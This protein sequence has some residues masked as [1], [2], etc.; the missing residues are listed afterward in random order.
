MAGEFLARSASCRLEPRV[1]RGLTLGVS[2]LSRFWW[3]M[4]LSQGCCLLA[5]LPV[6]LAGACTERV[7]R[8]GPQLSASER[9]GIY[10]L[11]LRELVDVPGQRFALEPFAATADSVPRDPPQ[12]D[13][14]RLPNDVIHALER[15]EEVI[16]TCIVHFRGSAEAPICDFGTAGSPAAWVYPRFSARFSPIRAVAG[17]TLEFDVGLT[18]VELAADTTPMRAP[19]FAFTMRYRVAGG[20]A[21]WKVIDRQLTMIT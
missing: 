9:A 18:R 4:T 10:A 5:T 11:A 20:A 2:L 13:T 14:T 12:A 17:D 1:A 21:G 3:R 19:P 6:A 15:H 8:T 16:G 7:P